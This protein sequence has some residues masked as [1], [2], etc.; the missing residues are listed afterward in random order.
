MPK[1]RAKIAE[2]LRP[3]DQGRGQVLA[4]NRDSQIGAQAQLMAVRIGR[5]IHALADVFSRQIEER[6]RRLKN[7][8]HDPPIAGALE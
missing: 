7:C 1:D 4:R 5:K 3:P 6:S 8:G 2:A